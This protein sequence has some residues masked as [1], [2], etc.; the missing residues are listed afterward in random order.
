VSA[1]VSTG[2]RP[3]R[4][5]GDEPHFT[6]AVRPGPDGSSLATLDGEF[7]L[8]AYEPFMQALAR[9]AAEGTA[10][11]ID[12]HEVI[13]IDSTGLRGLLQARN[14]LGQERLRIIRPSESV[15]KLLT[16]TGTR[17][18]FQVEGLPEG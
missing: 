4:G 18:L 14:L 1:T 3:P 10:L 2:P 17:H 8:A 12:A 16:A 9:V 13:Y 5:D 15:S 6:I 7:D 11:T